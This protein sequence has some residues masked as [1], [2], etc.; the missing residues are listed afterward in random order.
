MALF[1]GS[2]QHLILVAKS[3]FEGM[4]SFS[5]ARKGV[6]IPHGEEKKA[7]FCGLFPHFLTSPPVSKGGISRVMSKFTLAEIKTDP[8]PEFLAES[9][10][11]HL[12]TA[13]R[14]LHLFGKKA[15]RMCL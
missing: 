7:L 12:W 4:F 1:Y 6:E 2:S 15:S 13:N 10:V 9:A 8:S 3:T 5:Q 11:C 14:I